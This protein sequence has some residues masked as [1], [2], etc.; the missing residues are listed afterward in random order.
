MSLPCI[1]LGM[2]LSYIVEYIT[3]AKLNTVLWN[4]LTVLDPNVP[5]DPTDVA[6]MVFLAFDEA[7][8]LIVPSHES[9]KPPSRTVFVEMRRALRVISGFPVFAFFL[10]TTGN[11]H[12]FTPPP[13][14]DAS[15]R[16]ILK[17]LQLLPPFTELGFDQML[18]VDNIKIR[19]DT[20]TVEEVSRIGFMVRFGRPL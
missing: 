1:I 9:G 6:P 11:I 2:T 8:G 18:S 20:F 17:E 12:D 4:L 16:L 13:K 15:G 3:S 5:V 19:P 10:S 14:D 7:H